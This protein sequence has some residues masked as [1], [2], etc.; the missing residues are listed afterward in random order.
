MIPSSTPAQH[1]GYHFKS[2]KGPTY[3]RSRLFPR[4][5]D[6]VLAG[7]RSSRTSYSMRLPQPGFCKAMM[8]AITTNIVDSHYQTGYI[9]PNAAFHPHCPQRAESQSG[10]WYLVRTSQSGAPESVL[11]GEPWGLYALKPQRHDPEKTFYA[12]TAAEKARNGGQPAKRDLNSRA[13]EHES[14]EVMS[15]KP[16]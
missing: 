7:Y 6:I 9:S 3:C 4:P 13:I 8:F 1:P 2:C 14:G 12:P 10:I 11:R 5:P 15:A 16:E